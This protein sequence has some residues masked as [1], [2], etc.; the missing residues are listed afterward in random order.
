LADRLGPIAK[1]RASFRDQETIVVEREKALDALKIARDEL[2]YDVLMDVTGVDYLK[3]ESHPERFA[4]VWNL[5][6]MGQ[7]SRVRLKAYLP[8]DDPTVATATGVW[9]AANWGEREAYDMYG[10]EF[11]GHPQL[12]RILMPDD[13]ASYPLRK[14]Y[15]LRGR[16]E[17]DNF[18]VLKRGQ[19][20]NDA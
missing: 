11:K 20:E 7:E 12:K 4:V 1:S 3:L 18:V 6:S 8:E 13:Y 17:R 10:I 19:K 5:L 15:P 9:A 2:G 14:D 16:G